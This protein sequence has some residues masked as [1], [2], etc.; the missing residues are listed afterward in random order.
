LGEGGCA[1]N[2]SYEPL[3][4]RPPLGWLNPI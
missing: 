4:D 3:R 1:A 2:P